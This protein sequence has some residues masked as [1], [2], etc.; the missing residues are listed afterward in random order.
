MEKTLRGRVING[1]G[2]C[3]EMALKGCFFMQF[4]E[5]FSRFGAKQKLLC[6]HRNNT[7][8]FPRLYVCLSVSLSLILVYHRW[9]I[10][11]QRYRSFV[12]FSF[13]SFCPLLQ[14]LILFVYFNDSGL[15]RL[16]IIIFKFNISL[17]FMLFIY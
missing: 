3:R 14:S 2:D 8:V 16:I 17:I 13:M 12:F 9:P 11:K 1:E 15:W 10:V 6:Y 5:T 4:M 7:T